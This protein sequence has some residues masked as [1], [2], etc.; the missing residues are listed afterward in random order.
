MLGCLNSQKPGVGQLSGL[1][2]AE[3]RME[4]PTAAPRPIAVHWRGPGRPAGLVIDSNTSPKL[5]LSDMP[6]S[7]LAE[8]KQTRLHARRTMKLPTIGCSNRF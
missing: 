1:E 6:G 5:V 2:L 7:C 3:V 8:A 4:Q